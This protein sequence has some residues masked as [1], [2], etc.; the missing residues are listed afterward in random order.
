MSLG[1]TCMKTVFD[2]LGLGYL[3]KPIQKKEADYLRTVNLL[4]HC[5]GLLFFRDQFAKFLDSLHEMI[6]GIPSVQESFQIPNQISNVDIVT[7]AE[8]N[9]D[10]ALAKLDSLMK[11]LHKIETNYYF[12]KIFG[13]G[14]RLVY[15]QTEVYKIISETKH[16]FMNTFFMVK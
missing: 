10:M 15:E 9:Y 13:V 14:T 4:K 1:F 8:Q 7:K 12:E 11:D 16:S 3:Y 2:C 5:Y 6:V